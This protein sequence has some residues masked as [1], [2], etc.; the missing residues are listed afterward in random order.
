MNLILEPFNIEFPDGLKSNIGNFVASAAMAPKDLV[1]SNPLIFTK[2]ESY[3]DMF[4]KS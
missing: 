3:L 4:N 1:V 2:Y